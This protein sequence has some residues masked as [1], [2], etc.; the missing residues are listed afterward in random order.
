MAYNPDS[1][2]GYSDFQLNGC[3]CDRH[4]G[5]RAHNPAEPSPKRLPCKNGSPY[6][7]NTNHIEAPYSMPFNAT[8]LKHKCPKPLEYGNAPFFIRKT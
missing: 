1:S 3:A 6:Y 2:L 8:C 7:S 4:S 5:Y